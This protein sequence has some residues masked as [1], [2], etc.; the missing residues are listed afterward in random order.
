MAMF[1]VMSLL[2]ALVVLYVARFQSAL[3][4]S[5][6]KIVAICALVIATLAL[7]FVLSRPPWYAVIIPLT[8]TAMVLTIAYNPQFALLMSFLLMASLAAS[9]SRTA[10][11]SAVERPRTLVPCSTGTQCHQ[12]TSGA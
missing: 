6:P 1:L 2:A 5:L 10:A 11:A 4:Q 8:L 7:G 3:A 9:I 12:S